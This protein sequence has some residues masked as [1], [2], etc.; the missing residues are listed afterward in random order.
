MAWP[1]ELQYN[2]EVWSDRLMKT[3]NFYLSQKILYHLGRNSPS[4]LKSNLFRSPNRTGKYLINSI[5]PIVVG[6]DSTGNLPKQN[7]TVRFLQYF[8]TYV[9][10]LH[11][12]D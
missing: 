6:I 5:V 1:S 12:R 9:L 7:L 2:K 10:Y 11:T 3:G 8:K 4:Q